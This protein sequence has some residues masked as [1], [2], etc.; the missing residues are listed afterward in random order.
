MLTPDVSVYRRCTRWLRIHFPQEY[1]IA[2]N[3]ARPKN[4]VISLICRK[5]G[6]IQSSLFHG[7]ERGI[8]LS[9][10]YTDT[11]EFLRGEVD[12]VT[13]KRFD[14]SVEA[15]TERWRKKAIKRYLSLIEQSRIKNSVLYYTDIIGKTYQQTLEMYFGITITK[16]ITVVV[17][18]YSDLLRNN[19]VTPQYD[20]LNQSSQ[21]S[22]MLSSLYHTS[23]MRQVV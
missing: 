13:T 10:L 7:F 20:C 11:K 23:F 5:L 19:S 22:G 12:E 2:M 16:R 14:D 3:G 15:L 1:T 21:L 18:S 9:E 4:A 8:Y 17:V 6:I